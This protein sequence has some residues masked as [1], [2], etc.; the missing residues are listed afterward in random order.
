MIHRLIC[1]VRF[2]FVINRRIPDVQET[3]DILSEPP[4]L[5]LPSSLPPQATE[6]ACLAMP[7]RSRT[8]SLGASFNE[9]SRANSHSSIN[10]QNDNR[11]IIL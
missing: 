2:L 6:V 5:S 10:D 4:I 8:N 9:R 3:T 7:P 11:P 1:F